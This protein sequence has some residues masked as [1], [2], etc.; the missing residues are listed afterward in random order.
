MQIRNSKTTVAVLLTSVFVISICSIL[1]ELLIS[2]VASYFQGS[3]I[4]HFSIVIG[5][6]LSSM[7]IGSYIS[8]FIKENLLDW[9]IGFEV[10]L[11]LIGGFSTFILYFAFSL[12]PYFYLI[13]FILITS[14]GILIGAEIPI[15]T[16]IMTPY[17]ELKD[18]LA[19]VLTFD[20][21]GA[22]IAS[23]IF[24]L[25]LLPM[26]GTMRTAFAIGLLNLTV[27]VINT[28]VFKRRLKYHKQ[29]FSL[30]GITAIAL[31]VGFIFSFQINRLFERYM[32]ND[33]IMFSAQSAYQR[34]V[35]T[36]WNKDIRLYINGNLQ[37]S[38]RDE[39]RYHEPLVHVPMTLANAKERVLVLGGGDGLVA[40]ELLKY[41]DIGQIEIVDLDPEMTDIAKNHPVFTKLNEEAFSNK[42]ITIHNEDA[43]KF[44][45][46]SSDIYNIIIL[47]LP[48]PNNTSLGKLYSHEFYGMIK[49]RMAAGGV[50]VTQSTSPYF[51]P[52]AFWCINK[53]L[54]EV[55]ETTLPY[56]VYVPTFGQWGFNIA[57]NS[58][59]LPVSVERIQQ[60][61]DT[62][63]VLQYLNPA[64]IPGLFQ[65]DGDMEESAV[66]INRL[67][68]QILV[69]YYEQSWDKMR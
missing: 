63:L 64:I 50:L 16:R 18:A 10:V 9:F 6:F 69:K 2:S 57:V 51:A 54:N 36:K 12:T 49:K 56:S 31:I 4:L 23:I 53:T 32:Y 48:D 15:L 8:R 28:T 7:G 33:Q 61:L 14:L 62:T 30:S 17:E 55:F 38:T 45:E 37:F 40:K 44:L 11:S 1:Y 66:E 3:S 59:H 21:L 29:L 26:L 27:A 43:Y 52:K 13:T 41:D 68:N 5:I 22:L 34:I 67:D 46:A 35:V 39:Y 42:K 60:N 58:P 20:Y 19:K 65:F 47:D 25:V 24:P